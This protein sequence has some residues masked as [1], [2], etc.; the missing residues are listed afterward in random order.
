MLTRKVVRKYKY[1]FSIHF[2]PLLYF[3]HSISMYVF[4]RVTRNLKYFRDDYKW[5]NF[6]LWRQVPPILLLRSRYCIQTTYEIWG[7]NGGGT[8][9]YSSTAGSE[10]RS[11]MLI[12]QITLSDVPRY[13]N[14]YISCS[15][16]NTH[17]PS[18]YIVTWHGVIAYYFLNW[19]Q[20]L[21]KLFFYSSYLHFTLTSA[22]RKVFESTMLLSTFLHAIIYV[23]YIIC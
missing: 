3:L 18:I 5:R 6:S 4:L 21:L 19:L 12:L 10:F 16:P 7:Y 17:T 15:V 14:L 13:S 22:L 8:G 20:D 11:F 1:K 2:P 9:H 23:V